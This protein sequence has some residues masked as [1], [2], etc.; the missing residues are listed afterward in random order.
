MEALGHLACRH[1]TFCSL[2]RGN[3]RGATRIGL[4]RNTIRAPAQQSHPRQRLVWQRVSD[5]GCTPEARGPKTVPCGSD[6]PQNGPRLRTLA[7]W[8]GRS[9]DLSLQE[10]LAAQ[11]APE[12]LTGG[13]RTVPLRYPNSRSR[14]GRD[15]H[16][17]AVHCHG[18]VRR[19]AACNAASEVNVTEL[20]LC[21]PIL[22]WSYVTSA[23]PV[24]LHDPSCKEASLPSRRFPDIGAGDRVW[25]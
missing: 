21:I 17:H 5:L 11:G 13:V 16:R 3:C 1:N 15:S 18:T 4:K 2:L 10:G 12:M 20:F 6:P 23:I 7:F 22:F 14:L 8:G 9:R 19:A 24:S 25:Q